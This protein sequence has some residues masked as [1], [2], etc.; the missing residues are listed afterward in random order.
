MHERPLVIS[1][2][3]IPGV[4]LS[5]AVRGYINKYGVIPGRSVLICTNN[6]D[7]YRTAISLYKIGI[8]VSG[9][10]DSRNEQSPDLSKIIKK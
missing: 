7:A 5:S 6:D 9:I 10:V 8:K 1:G 4:M 2:N 3:D